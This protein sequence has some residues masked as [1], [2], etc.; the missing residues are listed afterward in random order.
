MKSICDRRKRV[1]EELTSKLLEGIIE[2]QAAAERSVQNC[3]T[4]TSRRLK[5]ANLDVLW[6][7]TSGFSVK[8]Y[9]TKGWGLWGNRLRKLANES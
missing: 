2:N 1:S 3:T 4:I 8:A 5:Q 6:V 7:F 9:K